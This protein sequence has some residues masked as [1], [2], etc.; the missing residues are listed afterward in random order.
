M[1][2]LAKDETA[3]AICRSQQKGH[4]K[5]FYAGSYHEYKQPSRELIEKRKKETRSRRKSLW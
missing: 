3:C 2:K 1:P 5:I 4:G